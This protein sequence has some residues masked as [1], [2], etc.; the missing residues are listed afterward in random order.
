MKNAIQRHQHRKNIKRII[1][2]PT[3][4]QIIYVCDPDVSSKETEPLWISFKTSEKLKWFTRW[5]SWKHITAQGRQHQPINYNI[6]IMC[7]P[8]TIDNYI[9]IVLYIKGNYSHFVTMKFLY[10]YVWNP[11]TNLIQAQNKPKTD[12]RS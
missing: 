6:C 1:E 12:S 2:K 4:R 11:I 5:P 7:I 8:W 9:T 10:E 3:K